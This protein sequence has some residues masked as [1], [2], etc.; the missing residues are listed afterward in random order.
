MIV[1]NA[2]PKI[3]M[4]DLVLVN[5]DGITYRY[6]VDATREVT[7]DRVDVLL[8]VTNRRQLTLITCV[9]LGTYWRR[10]VATATLVN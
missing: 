9:P 7:P 4:G 6:K 3:T 2:L 5:Y 10:F 1:F 8:P